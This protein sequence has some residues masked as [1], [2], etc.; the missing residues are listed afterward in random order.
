MARK[1]KCTVKH[2]YDEVPWAHQPNIDSYA[3]YVSL[4]YNHSTKPG[5]K[6]EKEEELLDQPVTKMEKWL[7]D[8]D[9]Q[10]YQ[11]MNSFIKQI[12]NWGIHIP[13]QNSNFLQGVE[14]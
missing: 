10:V 5:L 2:L 1:K 13:K 12:Y 4:H 6:L 11:Y 3:S 9:F 7:D 8:T 14:Q